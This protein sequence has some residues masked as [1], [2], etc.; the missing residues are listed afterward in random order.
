M[1]TSTRY[2]L[3]TSLILIVLGCL[4]TG[5]GVATGGFETAKSYAAGKGIHLFDKNGFSVNFGN[6]SKISIGGNF[7]NNHKVLKGDVTGSFTANETK[8]V[9]KVDFDLG[10]CDFNFTSTDSDQISYEISSGTR[11]Q[12]YISSNTL[13]VKAEQ[14]SITISVPKDLVLEDANL[15]IG[16]TDADIA[17]INIKKLDLDLGTGDM[18]ISDAIIDNAKITVGAGNLSFH[19]DISGDLK[20]ECGMGNADLFL[21]SSQDDHS[22][23]LE[24]GVGNIDY[25]TL[26]FGGV[27]NSAKSDTNPASNYVIQCGMGNI[28][29]KFD[30]N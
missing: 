26:S 8:S 9:N 23:D 6:V 16:A 22:Y 17:G 18:N 30:K 4:L 24:C 10:G 3:L 1:K 28:S 19:G 11:S 20:L 5:I 14:G 13:Y 21:T 7:D 12:V 29:I 15:D 27:G 2:L 25:G